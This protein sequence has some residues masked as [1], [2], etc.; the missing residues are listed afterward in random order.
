MYKKTCNW[1]YGGGESCARC[2]GT[3]VIN[4]QFSKDV[5]ISVGKSITSAEHK[6]LI[7]ELIEQAK[8]RQEAFRTYWTSLPV[9]E[10]NRIIKE[11]RERHRRWKQKRKPQGQP[12]YK[13]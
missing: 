4:V 13:K 2:R 12:S 10:K 8:K 9:D 6:K 5:P 7:G 1:C 3:G 11:T